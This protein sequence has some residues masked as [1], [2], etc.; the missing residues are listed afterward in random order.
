MREIDRYRFKK[1]RRDKEVGE[2][3][4]EGRQ[5]GKGDKEGGETKRDS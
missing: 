4:R 1:R 3:K 2:T 5:R